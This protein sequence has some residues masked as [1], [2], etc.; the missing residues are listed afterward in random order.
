MTLR[1]FGRDGLVWG[2]PSAPAWFLA[3][4]TELHEIDP[5]GASARERFDGVDVPV[6][7]EFLAAYVAAFADRPYELERVRELSR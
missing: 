1:P 4:P 5:L 3:P 2:G 7:D 6:D